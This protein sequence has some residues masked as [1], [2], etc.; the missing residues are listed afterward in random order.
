VKE[1]LVPTVAGFG[2]AA[3]A[4]AVEVSVGALIVSVN[5]LD[6]EVAKPLLPE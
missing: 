3:S 6:V 4:T 5:T 1:T 2:E